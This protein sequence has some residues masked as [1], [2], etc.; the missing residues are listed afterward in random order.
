M[1][2]AENKLLDALP[3]KI[4]DEIMQERA[5]ANGC[6]TFWDVPKNRFDP[7]AKASGEDDDLGGHH[8]RKNSSSVS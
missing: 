5:F 3:L 6:E 2:K 7:C 4:T 1:S 8:W